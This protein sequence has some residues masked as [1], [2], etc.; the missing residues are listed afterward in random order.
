MISFEDM[1]IGIGT[2]YTGTHVRIVPVG[3]LL[4]VYYGNE[5]VRVAAL[6]RRRRYQ[7]Q[8]KKRRRRR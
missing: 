7:P 4:H 8:G 6:D 3:E 1:T 2:R 5:L